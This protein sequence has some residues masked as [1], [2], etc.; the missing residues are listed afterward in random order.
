M[1]RLP[2]LEINDAFPPTASAESGGLLAAGADLSA[3]RLLNA[4]QHGIFPWY[5]AHEPILWWSPAPRCV[6]YPEQFHASRSLLKRIRNHP[7]RISS[8][9]VFADVMLAC[10]TTG[11]RAQGTWITRNMFDAYRDMHNLGWA[12]SVEVWQEDK[13]V[14]GVYGLAIGR[15]FFGESMF[16]CAADAS[17]IALYSLCRALT[18]LNFPLL[19]CQVENPH[20]LSLG[21]QNIT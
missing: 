17:K 5:S 20:L 15:I 14:G 16:S 18:V 3:T 2:W 19:D 21:A 6:I 1:A 8:N 9:K 11:E 7:F 12:H 4:Y 10:A 13:L